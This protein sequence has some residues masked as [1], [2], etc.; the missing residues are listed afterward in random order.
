MDYISLFPGSSREKPKFMALAA[1]VLRQATD[2]ITLARNIAPGF[3]F[4]SAAG[5]QLDALGASVGSPRQAGWSDETYRSVLLR[6][7]KLFTWNGMN[8]TV[9]DYLESGETFKD[10]GNGSVTVSASLPLPAGELLPVPI[11]V[12]T[13]EKETMG[14]VPPVSALRKLRACPNS[15]PCTT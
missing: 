2:L 3:S 13:N 5:V 9:P 4:A 15:F 10:N 8:E 7:L 12:R 11:G 14:T 1:A 6:K